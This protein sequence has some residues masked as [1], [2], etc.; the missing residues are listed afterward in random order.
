M[1][2]KP[3]LNITEQIAD[4]LADQV[5]LGGLS[6]GDRIQEL[7]IA[8]ELEVSRGSVREAL[9]ILER[10]HL[11]EVVP[12]KG[13][14]VNSIRGREAV[15]LIDLLAMAEQLWLGCLVESGLHV[16]EAAGEAVDVMGRAARGSDIPLL[17]DARANLYDELLAEA[18]SYTRAVFESL[19]PSSQVVMRRLIQD[20]TL[21]IHDVGRYYGALLQALVEADQNRLEELLGAFHKRLRKL[22]T[23][24]GQNG[25]DIDSQKRYASGHAGS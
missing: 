4:R 11:I 15:A 7:R 22:C 1:G 5:I 20:Q 19:L 10:R 17:V 12:R 6:G 3:A 13:A 25:R 9:L 2:F 14:I 8:R 24:D 16:S 21:E 18:D 23:H